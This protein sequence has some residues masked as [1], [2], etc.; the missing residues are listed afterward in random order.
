MN[1]REVNLTKELRLVPK[2]A[3][4][5][6][7]GV[8]LALHVAL[9]AAFTT[10]PNP[11]PLVLQLIIALPLATILATLVLLVGYV[12]G[13]ARRRGL[14]ALL[15]TL[16]VALVPSALGLIVYFVVRPPILAPCAACGVVLPASANFCPKCGQRRFPACAGC[17]QRTRPGDRYC[18]AC[19]KELAA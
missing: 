8:F 15:W 3:W 6:G 19:G 13:D 17:G 10:E 18:S 7:A 14:N 2:W 5:L 12:N 9:L 1:A 16:V 4:A 11:P